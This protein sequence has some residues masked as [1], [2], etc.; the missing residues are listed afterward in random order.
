MEKWQSEW[1]SG[2]NGRWTQRLIKDVNAWRNRKHGVV[3]FH[4]TQFLSNHGCFGQYL[5][6]FGKIEASS[7]VD[8]Q[9]PVDD[10]EHVFF[11]CDRWWRQRQALEVEI[12]EEATPENIIKCML[13]SRRNWDAVRDFVNQVQS[14]REKEERERQRNQIVTEIS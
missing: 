12:E 13:T 8:C 4:L 3:D 11:K 10:A 1:T 9:D 14:T 6:R 7:C 5:Q 2:E